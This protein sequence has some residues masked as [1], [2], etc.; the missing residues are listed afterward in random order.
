MKHEKEENWY[1]DFDEEF[2]EKEE[3]DVEH[4]KEGEYNI[5]PGDDESK[6]D[7]TDDDVWCWN[8]DEKHRE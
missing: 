8:H 2:D 3:H 1:S 4:H 6:V 5:N 7:I